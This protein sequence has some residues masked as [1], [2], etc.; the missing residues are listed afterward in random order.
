M[1]KK[2]LETMLY[3][4]AGVAA[5]VVILI[6][7][8]F[9]LGTFNARVD[10]TEGSVYTLS[11]GTKTILSKLEAPVKIRFYYSQTSAAV[12]VGLKTFAKRVEDVLR[13]YERAGSGKVVIEKLNPEPDSDAEDSATLDGIEG[14][15]TNTQEKFY[16]GLTVSFLDQRAALPVL[17]PDRE[18]LLEYDITRAVSRVASTTKPVIGI[19]SA[20]PVM[21]RPLNPMLKQ[22]PTEPWVLSTELQNLFTVRKVEL[23]A[24]QIPDDIKVLLVIHPRDVSETTEYALDQFILR[25]GKMIAFLD[26]YAYFDQQPDLQNPLGGNAAGQ[27]MFYRLLKHWGYGMEM[28]K[29]VADLTYASGAGPRILPTLL[30]LTPEALNKDDVV[31]SQIGTMLVPFASV[32]TGKPAE[33]LTQTVLA[34]T[35]P[36]SMLV[37]L[38]IATLSGEPSTR[39]FQPSGSPY[40][41]AMRLSGKFK[42][43]FPEG[44]PQPYQRPSRDGKKD[45]PKAD[46]AKDAP[47][48][49]ESAQDNS[50][51]LVSDV[52]LLTDG[53]AV[54]V[55]EIFGQRLVVPRNGNL[56]FAQSLVE[57]VAGDFDLTKLR[58]R[59][60]FTRPLTV[61]QQMEARAQQSYLGKIKELEDNLTQTQEKLAAL[62]K[63]RAGAASTILTPEQQA[64]VENFKIKA[65]ETRKDLKELRKNLRVESD[66]L[67]FWTKLINIGLV[68]LLV[69]ILGIVLAAARR[70][71]VVA[72]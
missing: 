72:K 40:P 67:Q 47:Q 42:T 34:Q 19:M 27:S 32:F 22:Q 1:N 53:A 50:V 64:E 29:V 60:A 8:N 57:Q 62:Q 7:V 11:Q 9:L 43:A 3:S 33:G 16:L 66:A 10:L 12:P 38:I 45:E 41:L 54:E 21:G 24:E 59:A 52:D 13:E 15:L 58:S 69:V 49:K 44:K 26:S 71:K 46:A 4:T 61:I 35:S 37:D 51:V 48:L 70:R 65:I 56:N 39:G 36:N 63:Q 17:A 18:Q 28:G 2:Y 20:L 68:P 23:N 31:T 25:G 6:A 5:L 30:A 55:Q 14:Q